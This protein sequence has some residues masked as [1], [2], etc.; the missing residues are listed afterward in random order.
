MDLRREEQVSTAELVVCIDVLAN[1]KN[2]KNFQHLSIMAF[3]G[4]Y[5][6]CSP[7]D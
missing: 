7:H 2:A 4:E 6:D 5:K 1:A 3:T